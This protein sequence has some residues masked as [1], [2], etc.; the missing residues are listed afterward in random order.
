MKHPAAQDALRYI[1][2]REFSVFKSWM[3]TFEEEG[4][5]ISIRCLRTLKSLALYEEAEDIDILGLAYV[6]KQGECG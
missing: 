1:K 4:D 5:E 3:D 6:M 2:S